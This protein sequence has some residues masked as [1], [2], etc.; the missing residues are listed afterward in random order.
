[1][2]TG[3][4]LLW[5]IDGTLLT[6]RGLGRKPLLGAIR[7]RTGVDCDYDFASTS[8]LTDHQ[9]V[10]KIL[11]H[12]G[13]SE[14]QRSILISEILELYCDEYEELIPASLIVP[15]NNVQN[16]LEHLSEVTEITSL[17]CTGNIKRGALLKLKSA[18]LSR[19]FEEREFFCSEM[20]EP[21]FHI[22]ERASKYAENRGL[23]P[24]VIG[25]TIHD[26][27]GSKRAGIACVALE[28]D[29]YPV[30]FLIDAKPKHVLKLGWGLPEFLGAIR[31]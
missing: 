23:S 1:M 31:G 28:S 20:L 24:I 15:L 29:G 25:D 5:D 4:A 2:S 13:I 8:G 6:T 11:E 19:F 26:V 7:Q 21:R 27:E 10:N 12:I 17:I 30:Q 9:I 3:I 18:G 14:N 22:I 16:I